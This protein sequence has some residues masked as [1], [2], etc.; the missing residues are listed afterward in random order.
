MKTRLAILFALSIPMTMAVTAQADVLECE[1]EVPGEEMCLMVIDHSATAKTRTPQKSSRPST[2]KKGSGLVQSSETS[3]RAVDLG[4][5]FALR[6][7][8]P[9]TTEAELNPRISGPAALSSALRTQNKVRGVENF[10]EFNPI[11]S[12]IAERVPSKPQQ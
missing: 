9:D 5:D 12:E 3:G 7:A 4:N 11:L 6:S 10:L 8:L 1:S 2:S